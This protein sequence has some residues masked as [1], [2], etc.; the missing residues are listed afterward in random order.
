[1]EMNQIKQLNHITSHQWNTT[2]QRNPNLSSYSQY[3]FIYIIHIVH[4]ITFTHI[5]SFLTSSS[6]SSSNLNNTQGTLVYHYH[7]PVTS[8]PF[9]L[10]PSSCSILFFSSQCIIPIPPAPKYHSNTPPPASHKPS[11]TNIP[12]ASLSAAAVGANEGIFCSD[13][14]DDGLLI[15]LLRCC[16]LRWF[17]LLLV[18]LLRCFLLLLAVVVDNSTLSAK[19]S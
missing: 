2:T 9:S 13:D 3:S 18:L 11:A 6:T 1:M 5:L 19:V 4:I 8:F 12:T 16:F 7:I 10:F 15:L 17:L 14:D